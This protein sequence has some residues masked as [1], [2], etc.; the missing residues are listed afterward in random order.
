MWVGEGQRKRETQN[1]KQAPD[2]EPAEKHRTRHRAQTQKLQDGDLSCHS[3]HLKLVT[4]KIQRIPK[5]PPNFSVPA[6]SL[7]WRNTFVKTYVTKMTEPRHRERGQTS[8]LPNG[9]LELLMKNYS[10]TTPFS[11]LNM[12]GDNMTPECN[13]PVPYRKTPLEARGSVYKPQ[14]LKQCLAQWETQ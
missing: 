10:S 4:N 6:F 3:P 7:S 13:T 2:S 12:P 1:R 14:W 5:V 9:S 8:Y 11:L